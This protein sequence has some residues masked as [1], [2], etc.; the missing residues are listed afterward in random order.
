MSP[1]LILG[2]D[3]DSG[4]VGE[5]N[6]PTGRTNGQVFIRNTVQSVCPSNWAEDRRGGRFRTVSCHTRE[7]K[8]DS[9][10]R[11]C[12]RVNQSRRRNKSPR[13]RGRVGIRRAECAG[14]LK[15]WGL[16]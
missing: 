14:A 4:K 13:I 3:H 7:W 5:Q 16:I 15:G 2:H 6:L 10:P 11:E 9:F 1:L 12:P 8:Q